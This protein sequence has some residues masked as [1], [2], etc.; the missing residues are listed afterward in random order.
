MVSKSKKPVTNMPSLEEFN[1]E[2][3]QQQL[4]IFEAAY[5]LAEDRGFV[6]DHE[7]E[8]WLEAEKHVRRDD[9]RNT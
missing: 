6:P 7:L 4:M 5:Y 2:E 1:N 8:D 3:E 9:T